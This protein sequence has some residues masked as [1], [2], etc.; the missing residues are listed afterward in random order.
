MCANTG[1]V[2]LF[3]LT[4]PEDEITIKP[5]DLFKRE[6]TIKASYI[7]PL[8]MKRAVDMLHHHKINVKP[9]ISEIISLDKL[10][11]YLAESKS[12]LRNGKV[13]VKI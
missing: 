12:K 3:G 8:T 11:L 10:P 5:F 7:N 4:H 13:L 9:L 6:L 1:T 2:M